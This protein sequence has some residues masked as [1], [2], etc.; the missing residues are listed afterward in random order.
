MIIS[1]AT[2]IGG[3]YKMTL[4]KKF[5]SFAALLIGTA[6]LA[7][8][9]NPD[10]DNNG[11]NNDDAA[12]G[13]L[14][15]G[16]SANAS[17][18][19]PNKYT[20]QYEGNVIRQIGDTLIIYNEDFSEFLPN[21]ATE[22]SPSED[23]LVYNFK[24]RNDV[25]FQPG[26]NQDGRNMTAEDV[27][28]S[29]ERSA[30]DSALNR[31]VGI[32][33][34]EVVDEYEI[35]ILLETPNASLLAMLTDPGNIIIPQ[36]E[37]DGWGDNFGQNLIGTGPFALDNIQSGQQIDLVKHEGYWGEEPNLD[38]V[39]FKIIEDETQ[40]AN[41]LLA[42]DVHVATGV[43]GQNRKIIDDSEDFELISIPGL[44]TAYL[45]MNMMEGPTAD[46]KVR[47]AMRTATDVEAIIS[48]VNQWGGAE[49][50]YSPLP[51]AS[52]GYLDEAKD[53]VPSY[54]P[55]KA[56]ELLAETDYA[57][58][59]TIELFASDARVPYA[60]IFQSQM[61]DNLNI[62]VE[63]N[64]QEWGTYSATVSNGQAPLNI[65]G[66]SWDPDPF[67]Y[68]NKEFHSSE[69]GSLGNGRG[70][71]NPEV[72]ALLDQALAETDQT[73]RIELYHEVQKI[74]LQDN[75]RIELE[76]TETAVG[77]S[78]AVEGYQVT[79]DSKIQIVTNSGV[80]VSLK[81]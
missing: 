27:K 31:L 60:V 75:S 71:N 25:N 13:T 52:W 55:E 34:V 79:S 57:D 24:L 11:T 2:N 46:P 53:F 43:R 59:F 69:I 54:D 73:K 14:N 1:F 58:G 16:L 76:L 12:G 42:G 77:L 23:G 63:I 30:F 15:V 32:E 66:W 28:Y 80:N 70:Y 81:K 72:D 50:S 21:L 44:A 56:K 9:G 36:E 29:L 33:S 7:A 22:W 39:S 74:V 67:F 62:D 78:N 61:K 26:E 47:E 38:G 51:K 45:D 49:A 19:D 48:G 20:G 6:V 17:N 65:G 5:K 68:L 8:C 18:L 10:V 64:T 4:K 40:M 3:K 41:S 37:V 35:N